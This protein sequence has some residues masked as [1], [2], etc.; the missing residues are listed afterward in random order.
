MTFLL[1]LVTGFIFYSQQ[2]VANATALT[3]GRRLGFGA[4]LAVLGGALAGDALWAAGALVVVALSLQVEPLRIIF[5]IVGSFFFLRLAWGALLDARQG[6]M[7]RSDLSDEPGGWR[8]GAQITFRNPYALGF[9]VGV[10]ALIC[11]LTAPQPMGLDYAMLFL[12]I[13][14]GAGVW[15]VLLAWIGSTR[16][17]KLPITFFR[18]VNLLGGVIAVLIGVVGLYAIVTPG[19][20]R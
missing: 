12:G 16:R 20:V 13:V 14:I 1:A 17:T 10:T 6:A 19:L 15:C 3:V 4:A 18:T 9:W 11:L 5:G 8:A 2:V 7:P